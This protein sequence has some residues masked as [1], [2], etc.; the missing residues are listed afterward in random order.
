MPQ[1]WLELI[2]PDQIKPGEITVI[3]Q[4]A[5][6]DAP[7][8]LGPVPGIEWVCGA[9]EQQLIIGVEPAAGQSF[10]IQCRCGAYNRLPRE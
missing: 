6:T 5:G 9:C 10:A 3:T 4:M 2:A 1:R 8:I 7:A